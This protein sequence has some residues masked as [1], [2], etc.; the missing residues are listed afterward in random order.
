M[1]SV[2]R[3]Y[4]PVVF[5]GL[6]SLLP[7]TAAAEGG[8]VSVQ[9]GITDSRDMDEFGNTFK[10]HFG[11]NITSRIALEFGLLDMG[12]A[13]YNDPT[14]DFTDVDDDTPPVFYNAHHGSVSRSVATDSEQAVST[15]TGFS[16]AHPQGFL[17]TFRYRI[18]LSD[19]LDFFLKTGANLW[20]ADYDIIEIKAYQDGTLSKRTVKTRQTSAVDQISGGG[21][22][23][24]VI[25]NLAV[26][27]E[28]ETT[29][30]DSLVFERTRFQMVTLGAQYEF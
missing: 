13:S 21:F 24:R 9:G 19:S 15:Y 3:R 2:A 17:I 5:A 14:A 18:P 20:W 4:A 1:F 23:W 11:P 27:A 10:I 6:I 12:T 30:M 29:P 7:V 22:L 25:P 8:F 16:S 28:L 26:R